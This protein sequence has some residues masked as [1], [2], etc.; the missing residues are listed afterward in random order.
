MST[1]N[2]QAIYE[3]KQMSAS[4]VGKYTCNAVS[5][6]GR[7]SESMSLVIDDGKPCNSNEFR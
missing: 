1:S 3:I 5:T 6:S 7:K 4:D 2:S